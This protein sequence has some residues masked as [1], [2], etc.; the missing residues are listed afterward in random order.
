M[1]E[2]KRE[3]NKLSDTDLKL[4]HKYGSNYYTE[5]ELGKVI[6]RYSENTPEG[7]WARQTL[8]EYRR[9]GFGRPVFEP[10]TSLWNAHIRPIGLENIP[11]DEWGL[12][13]FT[14]RKR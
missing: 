5:K 7:F 12:S 6:A 1:Y 8:Y 2:P 13:R 11:K 3:G 10:S 4:K 14:K 9:G